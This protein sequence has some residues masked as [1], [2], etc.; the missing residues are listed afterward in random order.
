MLKNCAG[1]LAGAYVSS[2]APS[3]P[4]LPVCALLAIAAIVIAISGRSRIAAAFMIG[5]S[6]MGFALY[7]QLDDRLR[8]DLDGQQIAVSVKI[9]DFAKVDGD[10]I[11]FIAEPVGREELPSR[12]RLTWYQPVAHPQIGDTWRLNI[13]LQRP[14]GYANPGGVD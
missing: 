10:A 2:A 9:V 6:I 5:V 4:P 12:L 1:L 11:R 8:R 3:S 13:R 14:H 7:G